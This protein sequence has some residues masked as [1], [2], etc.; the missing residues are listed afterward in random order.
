MRGWRVFN[1]IQQCYG[2]GERRFYAVGLAC[3][4]DILDVASCFWQLLLRTSRR[5]VALSQSL[6]PRDAGERGQQPRLDKR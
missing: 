6:S 4:G 1:N 5:R 2:N 3:L